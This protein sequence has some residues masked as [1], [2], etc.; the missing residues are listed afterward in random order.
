MR[1]G[2]RAPAARVGSRGQQRAAACPTC[3]QVD[4]ALAV[5]R[6]PVVGRNRRVAQTGQGVSAGTSA[7]AGACAHCLSQGLHFALGVGRRARQ[8]QRQRQRQEKMVARRH[9]EGY[10][11][12]VWGVL[13]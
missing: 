9:P 4:L 10:D 6:H 11:V 12:A 13:R 2:C 1:S 5:D 8:R 7:P 3:K